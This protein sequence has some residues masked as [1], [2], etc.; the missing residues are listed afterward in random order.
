M[1]RIFLSSFAVLFVS[2]VVLAQDLQ[3]VTSNGNETNKRIIVNGLGALFALKGDAGRYIHWTNSDNIEKAWVGYGSSGSNSFGIANSLGDITVYSS[4]FDVRSRALVNSAVDDGASALIVNGNVSLSNRGQNYIVKNFATFGET[5]SGA[6]TIIGNNAIANRDVAQRVDYSYT[7]SDGS[8]AMVMSYLHGTMFHVKASGVSRNAGEQWFTV[9]NGVDEVMRLTPSHNVLIGTATDDPAYKLQVRGNVKAQK[10]KVT[11]QGWADFVFEP[12]YR[13]PSLFEVE[14]F[15]LQHKH[16]PEIPS[17][18]E[19]AENG[20]D[21]G[22]MNKKLLQKIE[23]QTL[24]II[25]I[26]KRLKALEEKVG[27]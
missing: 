3:T 7:T 5:V 21:L 12:E 9:G 17:A 11:L 26:N 6:A 16:L 1:K 4:L 14:Q 18:K 10:V 13:L 20:V 24:Y 8:N 27:K 23:E 25:E 2:S 22:E 19:V 15:I